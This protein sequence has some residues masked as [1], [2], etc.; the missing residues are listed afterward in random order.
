[1]DLLFADYGQITGMGM[2]CWWKEINVLKGKK[3]R[4]MYKVNKEEIMG[5]RMAIR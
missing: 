5:P 4:V 2:E 1:M 3:V